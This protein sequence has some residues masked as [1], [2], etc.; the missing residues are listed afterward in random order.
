VADI[1]KCVA[2]FFEISTMDLD[3]KR[4]TAKVVLPRQIGMYLAKTLTLR[5]FPDIGM[6]FGGRDHTTALHSFRKIE[7]LLRS[8]EKLAA[9]IETIKAGIM[10]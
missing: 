1:K 10:A 6:R 7:A 3:S 2:R 5:S 4:R 8:D 9:D